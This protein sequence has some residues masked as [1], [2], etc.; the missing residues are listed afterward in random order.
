MKGALKALLFYGNAYGAE[1]P[2][3]VNPMPLI[4]FVSLGI[5][6]AAAAIFE[7]NLA[8]TGSLAGS[9]VMGI[10]TAILGVLSMSFVLGLVLVFS[11]SE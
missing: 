7:Y 11:M 9:L 2:H 6:A 5:L 3:A 4:F 8:K 1:D 10:T